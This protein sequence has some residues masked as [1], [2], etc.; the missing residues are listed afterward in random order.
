MIAMKVK[1]MKRKNMLRIPQFVK[2]NVRNIQGPGK[3]IAV[4]QTSLPRPLFCAQGGLEAAYGMAKNGAQTF[5]GPFGGLVVERK[6]P[7]AGF[8]HAMGIEKRGLFGPAFL[9]FV[10][11]VS[12]PDRPKA[13]FSK[14][15]GLNAQAQ[16]LPLLV[17]FYDNGVCS[18]LGSCSTLNC[19]PVRFATLTSAGSLSPAKRSTIFA[20]PET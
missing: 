14:Q 13:L 6:S 4:D 10:I 11:L 20:L 18:Q 5:V 8:C 7:D 19:P 16:G 15:K 12:F 2:D 3:I 17:H 1:Q 9:V